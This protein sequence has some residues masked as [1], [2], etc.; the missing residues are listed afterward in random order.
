MGADGKSLHEASKMPW[1]WEDAI[2]G[3][4]MVLNSKWRG[5]SL[6]VAILQ[7]RVRFYYSCSNNH[8][9]L[10]NSMNFRPINSFNHHDNSMR[11]MKL[12]EDNIMLKIEL[13]N[14]R[15]GLSS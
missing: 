12:R 2:K 9:K 11:K 3:G 14:D 13:L 1:W 6:C 7:T 8:N 15:A 10:Y 4:K 5:S